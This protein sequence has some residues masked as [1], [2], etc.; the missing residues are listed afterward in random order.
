M[1]RTNLIYII[2]IILSIICMI[3]FEFLYCNSKMMEQ[4]FFGIENNAIYIIFH[5]LEY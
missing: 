3:I 5:F 4:I 2:S 1:K